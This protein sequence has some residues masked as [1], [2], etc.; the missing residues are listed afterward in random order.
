MSEASVTF[1]SNE[2]DLTIECE[3]DDKMRDICQKYATKMEANLN[4]LLFLYEGK[5][6]NLDL[7]FK[8]QANSLDRNTNQMRVLV[9][10]NDEMICPKC[11]ETIKLDNKKIDELLSSN[12]NIKD[13]INGIKFSLDN[14][15]NNNSS[16]NIIN[17][18]LKNI[19]ALL[20]TINED[21]QK[22]NE[23]LKSLFNDTIINNLAK[24]IDLNDKFKNKNIIKGVLDIKVNEIDDN[25]HLFYNKNED[26]IDVYLNNKKIKMVNEDGLWNFDYNFEEDGKYS[27]VIVFNDNMENMGSFF[28][29]CSNLIYL[30]LSNFDSSKVTNMKWMFLDCSCLKEIKGINKLITNKV[31]DM[32]GMFLS[33]NEL[34]YLDL[35]N[36][37]TSNVNNM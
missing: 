27:F 6:L 1:S 15:I 32:S 16:N 23:K 35:S 9:Y 37:N 17:S 11:D 2:V 34:E 22:N 31:I 18:Q 10:K 33:C 36:F 25:F 30:D 3:M 26:D 14:I 21:I 12:E 5:Q 8:D 29:K 4:S 7:K 20:N 28:E 19:N 24:N 13:T